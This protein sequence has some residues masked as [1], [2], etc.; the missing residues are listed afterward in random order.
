VKKI[1]FSCDVSRTTSKDTRD[2]YLLRHYMSHAGMNSQTSCCRADGRTDGGKW[3]KK[4]GVCVCVCV[5]VCLLLTLPGLFT[6]HTATAVAAA[7]HLLSQA[8][9][10]NTLFE[11]S[12]KK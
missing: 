7:G 5:C 1:G 4:L 2:D 10:S 3:K 6:T 9:A 11:L 8:L 12:R